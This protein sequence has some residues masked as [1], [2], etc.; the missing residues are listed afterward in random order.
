MALQRALERVIAA[1]VIVVATKD[2]CVKLIVRPTPFEDRTIA[3]R[4][5]MTHLI[6][7]ILGRVLG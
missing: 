6:V 4:T 3:G 2:N 1:D 7:L 5:A